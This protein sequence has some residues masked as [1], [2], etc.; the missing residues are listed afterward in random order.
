MPPSS[1]DL[2]GGHWVL[3]V[4]LAVRRRANRYTCANIP[5]RCRYEVEVTAHAFPAPGG[6]R[7]STQRNA[8]RRRRNDE[9]GR[10]RSARRPPEGDIQLPPRP[11]PGQAK[12]KARHE[13]KAVAVGPSNTNRG[14][15]G[16]LIRI[17]RVSTGR[18]REITD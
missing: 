17:E 14:A 9:R 10:T 11:R 12:P 16:R 13:Y 18:D 6:P 3:L 7:P 4:E 2:K 15:V 1:Y 5:K 8:M